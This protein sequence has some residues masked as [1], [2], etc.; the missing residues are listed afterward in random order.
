MEDAHAK[1][2]TEVA[3]F[4]G[5]GPDGLTEDQVQTLRAQHGLNGM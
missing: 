4:Y 5:T 2:A 1:S 3:R